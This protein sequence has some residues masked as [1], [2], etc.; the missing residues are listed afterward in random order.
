MRR[1]ALLFLIV[2]L[3]NLIFPVVSLAGDYN[4]DSTTVHYEGLV[5]CG[6]SQP[7]PGEHEW[8]T[9]RCQFCHFFVMLDGIIDFVLVYIV[10]PVAVLMLV[11]GGVMFFFAG[12]RPDM[13]AKGKKLITSVII[14]LVI[15]FASYMIVGAVLAAMGLADT[16]PIK[17]WFTGNSFTLHCPIEL[18]GQQFSPSP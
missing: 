12:A 15:I 18:P 11:V 8:V 6:K 5:P 14:G 9:M 4:V 13:M 7:A 10:I 2:F 16:N 3:G 1:L 17:D